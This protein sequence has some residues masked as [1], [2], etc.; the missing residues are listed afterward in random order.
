MAIDADGNIVVAGYS[1]QGSATGYDFALAQYNADGTLD[2]TFGTGGKVTT[3]FTGG[4]DGAN[5]LAIQAD[6]KIVVAGHSSRSDV[7]GQDFALARYNTDG[8]LDAN[9]DGDG[10]VVTH[11]GPPTADLG[12]DVVALQTGGKILVTGYSYQSTQDQNFALAQY[13]ADGTL[14]TTFGTGGKV[15]TDFTG[16]SDEANG[17]AIQADGKIIVVGRSYRGDVTN[18][19]FALARYNIDGSLDTSFG[20][21]GKVTTD[22][23]GGSDE[24]TGVAIQGDGQIVVAG[25]SFQ[26]SPTGYDFALAR[27]NQ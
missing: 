11:I 13:N 15:T 21:D 2:T 19:D 26:G 20:T 18:Y 7:T 17:L 25:C 27:Y 24:V 4:S 10:K 9:F 8:S 23:A 22:F 1:I 14:D 16:G 6:G 12:S 5:G 3:D